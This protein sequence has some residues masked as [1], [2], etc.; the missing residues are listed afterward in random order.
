MTAERTLASLYPVGSKTTHVGVVDV[1][2][3]ANVPNDSMEQTFSSDART[4]NNEYVLG[5]EL[6][7]ALIYGY[8]LPESYCHANR[9]PTTQND[10]FLA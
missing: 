8:C 10:P 5:H 7:P 9:S 2:L 4:G 1:G 3:C 6:H